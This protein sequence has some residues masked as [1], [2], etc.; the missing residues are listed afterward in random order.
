MHRSYHRSCSFKSSAF[1]NVNNKSLVRTTGFING[2]WA[3][4][5]ESNIKSFDVLNPAN[6]ECIA[7]LPRMVNFYDVKI[8]VST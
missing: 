2:R 1:D 4:S 3:S 7:K 8:C 6:G 5:A